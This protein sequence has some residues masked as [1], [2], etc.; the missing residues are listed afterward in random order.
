[1]PEPEKQA[2]G[3][4]NGP[5]DKHVAPPAGAK[6]TSRHD[7]GQKFGD[8]E[9][10]TRAKLRHC[11]QSAAPV[12]NRGPHTAP[13]VLSPAGA[14]ARSEMSATENN[15]ERGANSPA[16]PKV[17]WQEAASGAHKEELARGSTPPNPKRQKATASR[18]THEG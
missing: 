18:A 8:G 1:M 15:F 11:D 10:D 16:F 5:L 7:A 6:F 13:G 4:P 3:G 9:R 14:R 17:G 12:A 2:A